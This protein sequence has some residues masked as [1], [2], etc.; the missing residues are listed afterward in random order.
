MSNGKP[1]KEKIRLMELLM[2]PVYRYLH[3]NEFEKWD[4]AE[5]AAQHM[6]ISTKILEFLGIDEGDY[7]D[8]AKIIHDYLRDVLTDRMD[9]VIGF[10]IERSIDTGER[11]ALIS[12][13]VDVVWDNLET[14]K[15]IIT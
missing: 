13:F 3:A 12:K 14:I 8:Q 10:P 9:E 15:K 5:K 1:S 2:M 11:N 4:G 7:I 6:K